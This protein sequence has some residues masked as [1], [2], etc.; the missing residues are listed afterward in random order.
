LFRCT[1]LEYKDNAGEGR[2]ND[3][4]CDGSAPL[5]LKREFQGIDEVSR[6]YRAVAELEG[7]V[8]VFRDMR[9]RINSTEDNV[10][11]QNL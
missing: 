10:N 2:L 7:L 6:I 8:S 11:V 4:L 3:F 1:K 5:D 9:Y